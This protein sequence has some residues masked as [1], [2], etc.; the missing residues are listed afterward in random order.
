MSFEDVKYFKPILN[1]AKELLIAQKDNNIVD[2][3]NSADI[4][5]IQTSYDNWNGGINYD[6]VYLDVNV[7]DFVHYKSQMN[8]IEQKLLDAFNTATRYTESEVFSQ[9]LISPRHVKK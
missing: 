3:L 8:D 7:A 1:T 6:T 2:I 9:V 5:V 4:S